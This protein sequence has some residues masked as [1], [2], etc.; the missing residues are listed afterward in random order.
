MGRKQQ[1]LKNARDE[2]EKV[3]GIKIK[4]CSSIY[5]T[6]PWGKID[7]EDFLN[8]VMEFETKLE[9]LKILHELQN[10]EIKMGRKRIEKWGPRI[11]DLD[12]LLYGEETIEMDELKVPH[13]FMKERLFVLIPLQ[14]INAE[15]IFPDGESIEEVLHRVAV[16]TEGEKI[17]KT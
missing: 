7:Q 2:I 8:Q 12:I 10:I 11:I 16:H 6:T 9:A 3:D 15:I 17:Q 13:P 14:E 4:N 5:K 1:N